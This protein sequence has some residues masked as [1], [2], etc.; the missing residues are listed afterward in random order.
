MNNYTLKAFSHQIRGRFKLAMGY[1][2]LCIGQR[3]MRLG[4]V[5]QRRGNGCPSTPQTAKRKLIGR[6]SHYII[7]IGISWFF[8]GGHISA[9]KHGL[10][11]WLIATTAGVMVYWLLSWLFRRLRDMRHATTR[12]AA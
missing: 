8:L 4:Q 6:V 10:G 7:A 12:G 3:L 5:L 2:M 9:H 1:T 11:Q